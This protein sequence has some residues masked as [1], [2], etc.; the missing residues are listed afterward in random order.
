MIVK[1]C[2]DLHLE[3]SY[4]KLLFNVL[5]CGKRTHV[6]PDVGIYF[7]EVTWLPVAGPADF[8]EGKRPANVE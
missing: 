1:I 7:W 8:P 4:R 3:A 5:Q 6:Y 2:V